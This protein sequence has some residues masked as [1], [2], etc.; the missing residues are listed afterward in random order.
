MGSVC[1]L[2]SPTLAHFLM[3]PCR[4]LAVLLCFASSLAVLRAEELPRAKAMEETAVR[5]LV[6]KK[7]IVVGK[8]T[9]AFESPKGMTFLNLEGGKFTAI[10]WKDRYAKF[11]GGS[12]AK[13]YKGKTVEITGTVIE[14][15]PKGASK[16]DPGKLEIK[17][18]SPEQVKV[19]AA[20]GSAPAPS[21]AAPA[22]GGKAEAAPADSAPAKAT[23]SEPAPVDQGDVPEVPAKGAGDKAAAPAEGKAGR[24]GAKKAV[25]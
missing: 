24:G 3:F 21:E 2:K 17:L 7:A 20:D 18:N 23:P 16:E 11:E 25:Q 8:V 15:R 6:G 22:E 5:A 13:L 10:A 19:I 14:F 1:A 12:P 9:D 4:P